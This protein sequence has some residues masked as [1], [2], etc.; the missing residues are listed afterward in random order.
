MHTRLQQTEYRQNWRPGVGRDKGRKKEGHPGRTEAEATTENT[1]IRQQQ[2]GVDRRQWYAVG[3]TNSCA[4]T[5][6]IANHSEG[7]NPCKGCRLHEIAGDIQSIFIDAGSVTR[8]SRAHFVQFSVLYLLWEFG[9]LVR[10]L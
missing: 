6:N 3:H 2:F 10:Q 5:D 9:D 7:E 4:D 8:R 1:E